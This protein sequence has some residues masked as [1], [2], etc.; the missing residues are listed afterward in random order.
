MQTFLP[1]PDFVVSARCLDTKRLGKQRV[2][3]KQILNAL[4]RKTRGWV[5][6]PA[7]KMWRGHESA[8]RLYMN[9]MII[10]WTSRGH[11]NSMLTEETG[12][13][14]VFPSWLGDDR[15]HRSHRSN[16]LRKDAASYALFKHDVP[17]DLPYFWPV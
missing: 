2:E 15:L 11:K 10:E 14:L 8:L 13:P 16:L 1:Y 5:N 17:D 9:V 4:A 7:V 6:H 12:L 3:A